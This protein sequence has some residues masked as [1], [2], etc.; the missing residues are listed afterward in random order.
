MHGAQLGREC[1]AGVG[2]MLGSGSAL[3]RRFQTSHE[4]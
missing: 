4:A 1:P 2:V 3:N